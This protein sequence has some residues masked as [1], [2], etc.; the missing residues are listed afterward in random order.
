[1][2][3]AAGPKPILG[4]LA[5]AGVAVAAVGAAYLHVRLTGVVSPVRQTV[6]D[7]ALSPAGAGVFAA[8]CLALAVG[9]LGLV[10]AVITLRPYGPAARGY[11]IVLLLAA[12]CLGLTV[13]ALFPT[14]PMGGRI[15]LDGETHRWAI[16]LAFVSLPAVG[17]LISGARCWKPYA[18]TLRFWARTGFVSLGVLMITYVPVVAP[19][20]AHG[21][22]T[23]G[24][25]ERWVLFVDLALVVTLAR[26][27]VRRPAPAATRSGRD[28]AGQRGH[29]GFVTPEA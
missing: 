28:S 18:G 9:S 8:M 7:Y 24:L 22:V 14:D 15:S 25:S 27:L 13:A 5:I 29:P 20:I 23:I 3:G 6:S 10:S 26:P 1:M 16:V 11:V 2:G 19:G 12:W 21:P 17:W 4:G